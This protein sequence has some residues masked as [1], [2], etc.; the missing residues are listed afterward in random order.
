MLGVNLVEKIS[1]YKVSG[2]LHGVGM[3]VVNGL[4]EWL[5]VEVSRE[6]KVFHQRYEKGKAVTN[7]KVIGTTKVTGTKI[8]FKPDPTIFE[9]VIYDFKI[10]SKR[11]LELSFLNK[12]LKIILIDERNDT[13]ETYLHNGGIVDFV[14]YLNRSKMHI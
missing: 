13:Q 14:K 1:G 9:E 6:G 5:E 12:G 3:S 7:L 10:I 11:L 4:S 8:T 2:G